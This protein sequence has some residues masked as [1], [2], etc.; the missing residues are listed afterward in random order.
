MNQLLWN[1]ACKLIVCGSKITINHSK[2]VPEGPKIFACNHP[3]SFDPCYMY[4]LTD[5]AAIIMT[6][7]VFDLPLAGRL[8]NG[9]G[10]LPVRTA[11]TKRTGENAYARA[12]NLLFQ[13]RNLLIAPEGKMS[14][15]NPERRAHNGAARL[16]YVSGCPIIPV[17]IR[18]EGEVRE[19]YIGKQR[20]CYMPYGKTFINVGDPVYSDDDF[21]EST[22]QLMEIIDCLVLQTQFGSV[23]HIYT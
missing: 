4:G 16:S 20:I 6:Q 1:L 19:F 23:S 14:Q 9:C 5:N 18:H 21:Y 11:G 2:L 7:F 8:V 10:F 12:L 3:T 17:G 15:C 13:R 22:C